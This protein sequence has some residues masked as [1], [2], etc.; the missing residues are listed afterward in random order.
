MESRISHFLKWYEENEKQYQQFA[1]CVMEKLLNALEERRML[2]AY[3]SCRAKSLASLKDKC[4]KKLY[5][6]NSDKY[7]FKY[8]LVV[9]YLHLSDA[10]DVF[11]SL[12]TFK[13]I[14]LS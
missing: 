13:A 4:N 6:E 10:E 11:T 5:D 7:I 14:M 1:E 2:H 9:V 12:F 3:H 8:S